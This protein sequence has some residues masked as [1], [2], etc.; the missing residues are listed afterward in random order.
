[1]QTNKHG[2]TLVE[3]MIVMAIIGILAV[4]AIPSYRYL[5]DG[6]LINSCLQEAKSYTND[7]LYLLHDQDNDSLPTAPKVSACD[8]ITDAQG[9][10]LETQR[11]I[12]ATVDT[13][14]IIRIECD[15]PNG[16]SCK[17]MP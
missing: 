15:V 7:V 6:S 8:T 11:K 5:I 14:P 12:I 1:M 9:W 16:G 4:I 13:S 17:V 2:F 3:L 10:T